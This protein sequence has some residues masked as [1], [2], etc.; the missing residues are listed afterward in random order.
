MNLVT[1]TYLHTSLLTCMLACLLTFLYTCLQR[2]PNCPLLTVNSNRPK[3]HNSHP[4]NF[5]RLYL[6][7]FKFMIY[8]PGWDGSLL[9]SATPSYPCHQKLP[10]RLSTSYLLTIYGQF[11][12]ASL[13]S[14]V[15][16]GGWVVIIRNKANSVRL[17]LPTGTELGKN[18]LKY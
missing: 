13:L 14:L 16:G 18:V 11:Q 5:H 8:L 7:N 6:V 3:S 4:L 2:R 17:N 1:S 15:G 9:C 12:A 10:T